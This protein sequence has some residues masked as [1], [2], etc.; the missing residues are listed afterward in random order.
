LA[1]PVVPGHLSV[2][3][4]HPDVR[5]T[6]GGVRWVERLFHR[7]RRG[8]QMAMFH[9]LPPAS[10]RRL[11]H[12]LH[13]R[14]HAISGQ[15]GSALVALLQS[16]F[17]AE[18]LGLGAATDAGDMQRAVQ[19]LDAEHPQR[20]RRPGGI[21]ARALLP[22]AGEC[23]RK[24]G[25]FQRAVRVDRG[26]SVGHFHVGNRV[27]Q[28]AIEARGRTAGIDEVVTASRGRRAAGLVVRAITRHGCH[29]NS[30]GQC[31]VAILI[32]LR[33]ATP[34]S[35]TRQPQPRQICRS[36]SNHLHDLQC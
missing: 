8:L 27:C 29:H 34:F 23:R 33:T 36:G 16:D 7:K 12:R 18:V 30:R 5:A 6:H 10:P 32:L 19:D 1:E 31:S 14:T 3:R 24:S 2:L 9:I 17:V 35:A 28:E 4:A 21:E 11:T 20:A 15:A 22:E 25:E 26:P 13:T